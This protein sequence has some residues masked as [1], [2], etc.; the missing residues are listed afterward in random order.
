MQDFI[1]TLSTSR[2]AIANGLLAHDWFKNTTSELQQEIL[3]LPE[4]HQGFL[5]DLISRPDEIGELDVLSLK[6]I[7]YGHFLV[8]LVFDV[9]SNITNQ[10]F[11]YEY[12]SWKTGSNPGARG[13]IFLETESKVTHFMVSKAHKFSSM[14]EA[15]DSIGGLYMRFFENKPQNL[16]KKTEQEICF[17]L[18][19]EKLNFTKIIDLGKSHPDYGMTNN[20]SDLFAAFIDISHLPKIDP[21]K[22]F[23]S[24]H[25]PTGFELMILPIGEFFQY[26]QKIDDNYFLSAAARI[27]THPDIHLEI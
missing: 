15:Y 8:L 2:Q 4:D 14:T 11:T 21:T 12:T 6:K 17:H 13:I 23:R 18:G 16:P 26:I 9:R 10:V 3:M 1:S 27:L 20:Q 5:E 22:E 19:I 24:T 7:S 25:K